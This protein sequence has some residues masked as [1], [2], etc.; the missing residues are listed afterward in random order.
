M[1]YKCP[2]CSKP[3]IIIEANSR[4]FKY[5]IVCFHCKFY[6]WVDEIEVFQKPDL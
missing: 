5:K 3:I 6:D 4:N 2:E 1:E